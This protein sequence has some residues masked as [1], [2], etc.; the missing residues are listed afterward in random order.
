MLQRIDKNNF[1]IVG[2]SPEDLIKVKN[3]K[4]QVLPIAGTRRRGKNPE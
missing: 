1:T 3:R 2:T 4:A